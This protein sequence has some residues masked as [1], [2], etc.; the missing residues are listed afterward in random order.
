[1]RW[2][3]QQQLISSIVLAWIVAG[4]AGSPLQIDEVAEL[5]RREPSGRGSSSIRGRTASNRTPSPA[6][7]AARSPNR[8]RSPSPNRRAATPRRATTRSSTGQRGRAAGRAACPRR[9]GTVTSSGARRGPVQRAVRSS[10][11]Q[12]QAARSPPSPP[13]RRSGAVSSTRSA[14]VSRR[15]SAGAA[16]QRVGGVRSTSAASSPS[17]QGTSGTAK[18]TPFTRAAALRQA[19]PPRSVR[20]GARRS[21]VRSTTARPKSAKADTK[22][23]KSKASTAKNPKGAS[24]APAPTSKSPNRPPPPK[25]LSY[26]VGVATGRGGTKLVRKVPKLREGLGYASSATKIERVPKQSGRISAE[27][28]KGR[29]GTYRPIA[30]DKRVVWAGPGKHA[31]YRPGDPIVKNPEAGASYFMTR[32]DFTLNWSPLQNTSTR[33]N[34]WSAQ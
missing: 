10:R 31:I 28:I 19:N 25:H 29:S 14:S 27:E 26:G 34:R 5:E 2:S 16:R 3:L 30:V 1:M 8:A 4:V 24:R 32:H 13:R 22:A 11:P 21:T 15:V 20:L 17:G 23:D 12:R 6:R 33:L 9:R 18:R 7:A